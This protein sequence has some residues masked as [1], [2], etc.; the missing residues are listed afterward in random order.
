MNVMEKHSNSV[1]YFLELF[2]NLGYD[3][4]FTLVNAKDY[5]VAEERKRVFFIGFRQDL[6]IDFGFPK[7]STK[8]DDKNNIKGYNLGFTGF[9]SSACR[10]KE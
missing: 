4:T 6:K 10:T 9:S 1:H 2:E 5:G 8:E 7:G 3:V